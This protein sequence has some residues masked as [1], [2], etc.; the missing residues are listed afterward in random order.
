[1]IRVASI[2]FHRNPSNG[3][4]TAKYVNMDQHNEANRHFFCD[5]VNVPKL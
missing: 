2:K 4:C 5:N 3:K 1:M